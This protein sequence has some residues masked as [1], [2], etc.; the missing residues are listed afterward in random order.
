MRRV[1]RYRHHQDVDQAAEVEPGP[2]SGDSAHLLFLCSHRGSHPLLPGLH[3]GDAEVQRRGA[4]APE[5]R[6][7]SLGHPDADA[8]M[9]ILLSQT[10]QIRNLEKMNE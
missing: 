3:Q 9:Q 2:R 5:G 1:D 7:Q 4:S 6:S 8:G 10:D